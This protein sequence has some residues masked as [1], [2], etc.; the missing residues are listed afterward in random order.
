M[1]AFKASDLQRQ[2]ADLQKAALKAPVFLTY[3]EKPRFVM[4]SVE[5]FAKLGGVRR[6]VSLEGLPD[7]VVSRLRTLAEKYAPAQVEL[8]GGLAELLVEPET[9]S[10]PTP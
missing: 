8:S 2:S 9:A 1:L 5:D 3:H 4:L 6:E 10:G 7:A